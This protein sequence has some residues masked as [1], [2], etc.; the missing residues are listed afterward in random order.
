MSLGTILTLPGSTPTSFASNVNVPGAVGNYASL[1]T[2]GDTIAPLGVKQIG[3]FQFDDEGD[4]IVS[5]HSEITDHFVEDNTAVQDHI[6]ISPVK[7]TLKGSISEVVFANT[8]ATALVTALT[9]VENGLSAVPAFVGTYTPGVAQ[10]LE[11]TI[12]QAQNVAVQIE[13]AASR[14][15]Q[16]ASYFFPQGTR[17]Q[18]AYAMLSALQLARVIFTVYTPFQVFANMAIED[19]TITQPK[20]TKTKSDI[21]VVMKQLQFAN[22]LSVSSFLYQYG[23]RSTAGFQPVVGN[24]LTAGVT[25]SISNITSA[26]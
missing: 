15:A 20:N 21:T 11:T 8:L 25:S 4:D 17:Q 19:F 18:K 13:Q 26:F 2:T 12:S 10:K 24:G 5:Q 3:P 9:T 14:A 7:I 22:S 1:L 6:G 16:I 23:G